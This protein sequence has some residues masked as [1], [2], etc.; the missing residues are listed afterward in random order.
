MSYEASL[1]W[2]KRCKEKYPTIKYFI[3]VHRDSVSGNITIND[4]IYAKMVFVVGMNHENYKQNEELMIRLNSY[5]NEH[6]NGVMRDMIY[7]KKNRFNQDFD[8]NSILIEIGGLEN[9]INEIYNST[10]ILGEALTNV[11]GG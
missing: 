2:L 10:L 11:I 4:R 8:P 1:I 5:L 9:N 6:Y 7:G 3:D